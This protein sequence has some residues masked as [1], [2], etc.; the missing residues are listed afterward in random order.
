MP[1]LP[2]AQVQSLVG[3]LR[4]HK[5]CGMAKKP[6]KPTNQ[7]NKQNPKI[8]ILEYRMGKDPRKSSIWNPTTTAIIL[9][10][11]KLRPI[12]MDNMEIHQGHTEWSLDLG[13]LTLS[14]ISFMT[15]HS[16]S[17]PSLLGLVG[18]TVH[19]GWRWDILRAHA[20]VSESTYKDDYAASLSQSLLLF[21]N[22]FKI[23]FIYL[24]I[25]IFGCVGSSLLW[26][27][28]L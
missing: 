14:Q 16:R 15:Q 22:I 23:L 8:N 10:M 5:P 20:R 11:R 21:F 28:F 24:F 13:L 3:E 4:F 27:G 18:G 25:Y 9:K 26:L 7:P 17:A 6:P 2:R 19:T 1:S 12:A